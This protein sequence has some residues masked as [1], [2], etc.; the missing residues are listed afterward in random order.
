VISPTDIF[1]GVAV[2]KGFPYPANAVAI[3][4]LEVL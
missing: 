4:G 2:I 3:G 1:G